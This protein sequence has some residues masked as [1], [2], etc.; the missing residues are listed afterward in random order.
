MT[1]AEIEMLVRRRIG[2]GASFD[3]IG[4]LREAENDF[5]R[6]TYCK[7]TIDS[8]LTSTLNSG[9]LS[10][11]YD[12][13]SGFLREF[14]LE[15]DGVKLEK[16][17]IKGG[18]IVYE[19]DGTTVTGTPTA[20]WIENSLIRLV[21]EPSAHGYLARWYA[22]ENIVTDG[23]SPV[24]PSIEHRKLVN[25]VVAEWHEINADFNLADR[26]RAQYLQDCSDAFFFY[27]S[28]RGKQKRIV[29]P[30]YSSGSS[31]FSVGGNIVQESTLTPAISN[32]A[33]ARSLG[34]PAT[35]DPKDLF[36]AGTD[37]VHTFEFT[38]RTT[39]P[40]VVVIPK[41]DWPVFV[42]S[43]ALSDRIATVT[44][45]IGAGGSATEDDFDYDL[46]IF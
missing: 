21:P 37:I 15:W 11:T 23:A 30:G 24:I 3:V 8:V 26:Y 36:N 35:G 25:Y 44:V 40:V 41:S 28:R 31:P 12:L 19:S 22:S 18:S 46:Q 1:F 17:H 45:G 14:R 13:P 9:T 7:E 20:Y 16:A 29:D 10:P 34:V 6:R 2:Q 43:V 32:G 4:M 38:S 5:C 27:R 33:Q 42:K 39:L